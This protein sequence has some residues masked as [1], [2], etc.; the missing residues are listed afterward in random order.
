[1]SSEQSLD[2]ELIEKTKQQIRS[3]VGEI[4]QLSKSDL[5]PQQFY[6]EFLTRVV[7]ALAAAGGAV[8]ASSDEGGLALQYQI[9]LEATGLREREEDQKKHGRLLHRALTSGEGSLVPPRSGFG[10]D[11]E[12][13]NT[14]D[15]LLVL[16]P[17]KTEL[18][19]LGL[20]EVFQRPDTPLQTQKGYLRFLLQMCELA[21][22]FLK[23]HQLRHFS[24]RQALWTQLEDF[25]RNIH[26][27][28]E[29]RKTAYTIA[30]EGRRLIDCDRVSVAIRRGRKC[31]IEAV[32]GQDLFDK[33]SNTVR[34]LG[35]LATEVVAANEPLWY[36]GDTSDLAPQVEEAL[37]EYVDEAHTKTIAVLPLARPQNLE[38]DEKEDAGADEMEE[39]PFG[40]LIIEQIEDSRV[41]E[42]MVQRTNV[43]A[44][45]STSALGNA[46][47]HDGLVLMPVWRALGKTRVVLG[48]RTLPK[49]VAGGIAALAL[50]LALIFWPADFD[51]HA[52]GSLEP[53]DRRDVYASI[54]GVVDELFVKH[55]DA[56]QKGQLL[57]MLRNTELSQSL[58]EV[59]GQLATARQHINSLERR[60][61]GAD[62]NTGGRQQEDR[63][64]LETEL[65][66]Y[67]IKAATYET[68]L[69]LL[70]SKQEDLKVVSPADGCVVTWEL[71][72][73]LIKRPVQRGQSLMRVADAQGPWQLELKMPEE[74]M[75]HIAR[76]QN[77]LAAEK[78]GDRA[79]RVTYILATEPG[80]YR[81]GAVKDVHLGAEAR[82]EE[83]STVLIKVNINK[84]D[85]P[86]EVRP[87]TQVTGKVACG[88]RAIGFV[89][90]HDALAFLQSRVFF[91]LW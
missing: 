82:A 21:A 40:A 75:G 44:R 29:P 66:E 28:L 80:V 9:N 6:G 76:A 20:V 59:N 45:H 58:L 23:S 37:Q 90:F 18:A 52:K 69:A 60:R 10:E 54:D 14:T 47:E 12:A 34:L 84:A 61:L 83:G 48:A 87:G 57:A 31:T 11:Q 81:Y 73:R 78:E 36:T 4:A 64:Q 17:L 91:K 26:A 35:R 85:L 71:R 72:D 2:P 49:V 56:V 79:L 1:M 88:R 3:L 13:A 19:V 38:K 43:V 32:S 27:S 51:L 68:Q 15:F 86:P 7:T 8:W 67:R 30:N 41:P 77:A 50:I 74:K 24:D 42:M 65:A 46:L 89:W 22:D 55:G 5:S 16:C 39:Q 33:R 70:K 63:A 53:V 62:K 25:T